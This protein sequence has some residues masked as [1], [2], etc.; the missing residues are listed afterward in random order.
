MLE[1]FGR[2]GWERGMNGA[3]RAIRTLASIFA[4]AVALQP[5]H[6]AAQ[7]TA[8]TITD[9]RGRTISV[10][11]PVERVVCLVSLCEDML[12]E[13]GMRP[14]ARTGELLEHPAFLGARRVMCR[15]CPA[16]SSTR[17]SRRSSATSR[18]S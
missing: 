16:G 10:D 5:S 14:V 17:T 7:E 13:L 8:T 6:A 9:V 3:G 11:A 2:R 1:T 15:R 4:M 12:L 18:N